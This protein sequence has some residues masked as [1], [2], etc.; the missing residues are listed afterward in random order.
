MSAGTA[1]DERL[2]LAALLERAYRLALWLQDAERAALAVP[3]SAGHA[4]G[5]EA[6]P[7]AFAVQVASSE[8]VD[9]L[10]EARALL[11]CAGSGLRAEIDAA[12]GTRQSEERG[13]DPAPF[14][15]SGTPMPVRSSAPPGR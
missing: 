7:T 9:V 4:D 12:S 15:S 8:L 5:I 1:P 11:V 6:T 14:S 2:A 10:D 13:G 3:A